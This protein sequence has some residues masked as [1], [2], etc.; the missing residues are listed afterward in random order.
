MSTRQWKRLDAVERMGLGRLTVGEAAEGLGLSRRQ[1]RRLRRAVERQGAKGVVHGNTGRAP[2]HRVTE[3]VRERIV[4]LRRKKYAGFNDQHFTEKLCEVE[5]EKISRASVQRLLRAAGIGPPRRRRAPKHRR[6]RDRK[7]RAGLMILWDGSRHAWLEERGPMLCL[8]GA[9]DDATGELLPGAHFVEQEC[10]AGYLRVLKA[11]AEAKGLPF[12]AY[13]D[14]HGSLKRNDDHWTLDEE[15]R[16]A[17]DPTQVGRALQALEIE[18]I[19]ALSPQAKGR[20]ERLWGTLQ[21]RLVSEL[22]LAGATTA[23]EANAVLEAF[24]ADHNRRFAIPPADAT[25]AWRAVRRGTDLERLCSFHYAATVL[26]DNTVRLQGMV[27]DIPP[28]PR[29]RSYAGVR[30]E[31]RQCLTGGWRVYWGDTVIAT[32]APT[33]PGELRALR[34]HR[35]RPPSAASVGKTPVAL[36]APSVSPTDD[37]PLRP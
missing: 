32:A 15:L 11:I 1:V 26:N 2:A 35:R 25:P 18:V 12:S 9:I 24:R 27:I 21:D 30:I 4:E 20:V 10:A 8:M 17:Q 37:T 23:P 36:R 29:K 14:R 19:Y 16:G 31:L 28:G 13:M 33:S 34:R 6:R 3:E 5:G 7:P 22:R